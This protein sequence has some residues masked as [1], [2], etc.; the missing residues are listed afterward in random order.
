MYV[1]R[2]PDA[3]LGRVGTISSGTNVDALHPLVLESDARFGVHEHFG[4][5]Q[6]PRLF[7]GDLAV[8]E[9]S[10]D[11]LQTIFVVDRQVGHGLGGLLV[12][13]EDVGETHH[14]IEHDF[15]ALEPN[16]APLR[17]HVFL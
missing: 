16:T 10:H 5:G 14:H 8:T 3:P 17:V 2:N 9:V 6:I 12:V 7:P 15:A 4:S 13:I 1:K 11:L